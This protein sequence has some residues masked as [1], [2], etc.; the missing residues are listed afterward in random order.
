MFEVWQNL[1]PFGGR[2]IGGVVEALLTKVVN[3]QFSVLLIDVFL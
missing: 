2:P 1:A 3:W